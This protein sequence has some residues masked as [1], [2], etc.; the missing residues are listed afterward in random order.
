MTPSIGGPW[1]SG[2]IFQYGA[3]YLV[4]V[5]YLSADAR[6]KLRR[7]LENMPA[8]ALFHHMMLAA[9]LDALERAGLETEYHLAVQRGHDLLH[10]LKGIALQ[11]RSDFSIREIFSLVRLLPENGYLS[12]EWIDEARRVLVGDSR[13]DLDL[14]VAAH[15]GNWNEAER[16]AR[17]ILRERETTREYHFHLG[18]A[19]YKQGRTNEAR[20][21][22]ET[23]VQYCGDSPDLPIARKWLETIAQ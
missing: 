15:K 9:S 1:I 7:Y 5:A 4:V 18:R 11:H 21:P 13:A 20:A 19:L 23:F 14:L 6:D 10:R 22:L 12:E 2:L 17:A 3:E 8:S 16:V